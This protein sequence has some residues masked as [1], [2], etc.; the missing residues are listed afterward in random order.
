MKLR[1]ISIRKQSKAPME[2]L[3]AGWV[4]VDHGVEGDYRGKPG[5]RQVT[6]LS[7]EAWRDACAALGMELP[8][9][10]RRANLLV[11]GIRFSRA[12]VGD[13]LRIG[14]LELEIVKE[15]DP[16][17]RMDA[18]QPGLKAALRPDWRGGVC[19]RVR[20]SGHVS[21]GDEVEVIVH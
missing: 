16:C 17:Q 20:K 3:Q 18:A 5:S 1:G 2:E 15:T 7:L 8:W 21:V 14:A 12:S 9:T 13:L 11:E 19:C 10:T 4:T 6:V